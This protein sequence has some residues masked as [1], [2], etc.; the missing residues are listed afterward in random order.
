MIA[1]LLRQTESLALTSMLAPL[2]AFFGVDVY[3]V[4]VRSTDSSLRRLSSHTNHARISRDFVL[5]AH[6]ARGSLMSGY[7]P[8][9]SSLVLSDEEARLIGA[10]ASLT[11]DTILGPAVRCDLNEQMLAQC[12]HFVGNLDGVLHRGSK[13]FSHTATSI[14]LFRKT[15]LHAAVVEGGST[16][17]SVVELQQA[18]SPPSNH[19]RPWCAQDQCPPIASAKC[20]S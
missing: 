18:W 11:D 15:I 10:H 6:C 1:P 9:D 19:R 8:M 13:G 7:A 5:T 4:V 20:S 12:D 3:G 16:V 2:D 14:M 17:H